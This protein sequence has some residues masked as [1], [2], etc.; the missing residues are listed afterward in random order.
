MTAFMDK[1]LQTCIGLF[2]SLDLR[3]FFNE[4]IKDYLFIVGTDG[5]DSGLA[6]VNKVYAFFAPVAAYILLIYALLELK[7]I[8][9]HDNA[10][11]E[12]LVKFF[13]T[14]A[15]ALIAVIHGGTLVGGLV[16]YGDSAYK[17]LI[18][19]DG[20]MKSTTITETETTVDYHGDRTSVV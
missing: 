18:G 8:Y 11:L 20:E 17:Q 2:Y 14:L 19:N 16:S 4:Q 13:L 1:I 5:V 7:D 6:Y 10:T 15:V 3:Y 9:M 12:H